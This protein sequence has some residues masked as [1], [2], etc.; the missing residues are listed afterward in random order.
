[1]QIS[2]FFPIGQ[3]PGMF[4]SVYHQVSMEAGYG[5]SSY[6]TWLLSVYNGLEIEIN[7]TLKITGPSQKDALDFSLLVFQT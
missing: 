3:T 1:M 4:E 2:G 6:S 7:K 5:P